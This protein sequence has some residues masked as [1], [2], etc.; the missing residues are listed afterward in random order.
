MRVPFV[1]LAAALA[2]GV[3]GSGAARAED[4]RWVGTPEAREP[5][6][7]DRD[8]VAR[9]S[10]QDARALRRDGKAEMAEA[11]ARRGLAARPKDAALRRELA[12]ALEALGRGAEA[13]REQAAADALDPPPP[14]LPDQPIALNSGDVLVVLLPP[15]PDASPDRRPHGWPDGVVAAALEE[16]LH[17]RLPQAVILHAD[18]ESVAEARDWLPGSRARAVLSVQVDRVY[19]GDTLKDGRFGMAWLRA[20]AERPGSAGGEPGWARVVVNEPRLADGC[21]YEVTARALERLLALARV[22]EILAAG[23]TTSDSWSNGAIRAL[24]PGL[25]RRIDEQLA[26]GHERLASGG[27][28]D[29]VRTFESAARI[30]PTDPVV[31]SYLHEAEADLALSRELA[32]RHAG[33]DGAALEPRLNPAQRAALESRL[34][35]ERRQRDQLLAA[36]A[37]LKEEGALPE[38]EM[39][40]ALQPVDI[41]DPEAFG[42]SLARRR[43][44]AAL[45]ARAAFAPDGSEIARYYFPSG[46]ALPVLREDD[47]TRDGR[48]D[49]WTAYAGSMRSEVWEDGRQLGR[50]DLRLV[51]VGGGRRLLRVEVDRDSDD[52][53]EQVFHYDEG[54]VTA[55]ARD[56]DGDGVLDTF[57]RFDDDGALRVRE[58]DL[59]GDGDVDIRSVYQAGRI[60]SRELSDAPEPGVALPTPE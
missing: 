7:R 43:A 32:R 3:L 50:P 24:F 44:G 34:A 27:I 11:V 1:W 17:V 23:P 58:E 42:P 6:P 10:L 14:P 49:R 22:R 54:R 51:F 33:D 37:V 5:S 9:K 57:D 39:L 19:C 47:T 35:K 29:A 60:L 53:P 26:L 8:R 21:A 2:A 52:R 46:D 15:A 48:P 40:E 36:L 20:A 13:A 4:P 18:F 12:R 25:G 55:Q 28:E 45:Q 16:R 41:P 30:D 59:D 56:T 31:R 38:P